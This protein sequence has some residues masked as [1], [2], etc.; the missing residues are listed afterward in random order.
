MLEVKGARY[1]DSI[2]VSPANDSVSFIGQDYKAVSVPWNNLPSFAVLSPS[3]SRASSSTNSELED[4]LE[5]GAIVG[6][7]VGSVL[8]AMFIVVISSYLYW[9]KLRRKG[10]IISHL[11]LR[12]AS[13]GNIENGEPDL[14]D[15]ESLFGR[16][17]RGSS[18]T[19]ES[20]PTAIFSTSDRSDYCSDYGTIYPSNTSGP[21]PT[22]ARA[23]TWNSIDG[24]P[25]GFGLGDP[26]SDYAAP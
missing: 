11:G 7:V 24:H 12:T 10:K 2:E 26:G 17:R 21:R 16:N 22:T 14:G 6:I 1:I 4:D 20:R 25:P 9:R 13:A 19:M 3:F 5:V 15:R 18:R 8:G 23:D